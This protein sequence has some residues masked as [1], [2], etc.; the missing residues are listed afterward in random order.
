VSPQRTNLVLSPDIPHRERNVFVFDRFDVETCF[1]FYF[2]RGSRE[3]NKGEKEINKF[4]KF[5]TM[6]QFPRKQEEKTSGRESFFS[7]FLLCDGSPPRSFQKKKKSNA[8][9]ARFAS[10]GK[11]HGRERK[12]KTYRSSES[13]SR[14]PRA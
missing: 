5:E 7:F 13:S 11:H 8:L 4:L 12:S 2:V 14:F 1:G 6:M 3:V 10:S 9:R